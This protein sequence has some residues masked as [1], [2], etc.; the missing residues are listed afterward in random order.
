M[1]L[2]EEAVKANDTEKVLQLQKRYSVL[3]SALGEISRQLGNRI[4][5]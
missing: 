4:L 1:Q 5:L 2:L 3:S